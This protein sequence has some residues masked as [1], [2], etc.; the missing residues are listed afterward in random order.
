MKS[1]IAILLL[2]SARLAFGQCGASGTLIFNPI[3]QQ[4]DCT[5]ASSASGTVTSVGLA[6]TANQITVTGSSPITASGSWTLS[7]PTTVAIPAT[8]SIGGVT[9]SGLTGPIYMTAG[10]PR[11]ATG[12]CNS[13]N[14]VF[15]D[16][17]CSGTINA[18]SLNG[19]A[20]SHYA[21]RSPGATFD[22]GGIALSSGQTKYMT[23][24]YSC[25]ISAYNI[26]AD[27]GTATIKVWKIATG[28]AIPTVSNSISTNGV[29]LATGT[30]IHST[31]VSDFTSLVVTANDIFGFNLFAVSGATYVNVVLQC[32]VS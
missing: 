11:I 24:P 16:G 13:S 29:S 5:G 8:G 18:T 32:D 19:I 6:G 15:G 26:L 2:S 25:T 27:T 28:T 3:S 23:V 20:A 14:A 10:V 1:F 4:F 12:T 7:F 17:T 9:L 21:I 30:A 31:T 22:G